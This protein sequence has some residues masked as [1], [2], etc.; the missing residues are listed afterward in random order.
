MQIANR[1]AVITEQYERIAEL[2]KEL[3]EYRE[4]EIAEMDKESS[5]SVKESKKKSNA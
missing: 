5:A 2:E 3:Q 4:K 1:D